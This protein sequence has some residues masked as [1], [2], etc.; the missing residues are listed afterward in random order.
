MRIE[1]IIELDFF[2]RINTPIIERIVLSKLSF[3]EAMPS[4]R[5]DLLGFPPVGHFCLPPPTLL[6]SGPENSITSTS[7][8]M[9]APRVETIVW[10]AAGLVLGP[11]VPKKQL[12]RF[13]YSPAH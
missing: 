8:W 6:A 7:I 12:F 2:E 5:I 4:M 11:S 1:R 13:A 9:G 10:A 3:N